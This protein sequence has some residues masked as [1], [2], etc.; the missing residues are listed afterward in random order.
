MHPLCLRIVV[1][2]SRLSILELQN[3]TIDELPGYEFVKELAG[4]EKK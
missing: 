1:N 3:S 2:I 4:Y